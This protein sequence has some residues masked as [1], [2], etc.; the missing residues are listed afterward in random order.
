V[1]GGHGEEGNGAGRA[2]GGARGPGVWQ[3]KRSLREP[4][5]PCLHPC[6]A[7]PQTVGHL[8]LSSSSR[9]QGELGLPSD[10]AVKV[11]K[12]HPRVHEKTKEKLIAGAASVSEQGFTPALDLRV[13]IADM[14]VQ[15]AIDD[16]M[17]TNDHRHRGYDRNE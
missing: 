2:D 16:M 9:G 13:R 17:A 8:I 6:F 4:R 10:F 12:Y 11:G 1:L 14:H 15:R 7:P 5:T 3:R